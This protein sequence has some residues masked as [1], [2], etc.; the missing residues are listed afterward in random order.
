[1]IT[2]HGEN[3]SENLA[4]L[5]YNKWRICLRTLDAVHSNESKLPAD[6]REGEETLIAA[7]LTVMAINTLSICQET[8]RE[9][10]DG[11]ERH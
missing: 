4:A 5:M 7:L 1:M 10:L 2:A 8:M 6:I 3:I 9:D 11:D